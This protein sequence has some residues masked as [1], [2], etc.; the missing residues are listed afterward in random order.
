VG[1][2]TGFHFGFVSHYKAVSLPSFRCCNAA[3]RLSLVSVRVPKISHGFSLCYFIFVCS[4]GSLAVPP[5]RRSAPFQWLFTSPRR[6]HCRF[7]L[8]GPGPSFHVASATFEVIT[9]GPHVLYLTVLFSFC[10]SRLRV[11]PRS[12]YEVDALSLV[13]ERS[14]TEAFSSSARRCHIGHYFWLATLL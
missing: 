7:Q 14:V 9:Q 4:Q 5:H 6:V 3:C 1:F 12:G 11:N 2:P 8:S 13:H 10:Q